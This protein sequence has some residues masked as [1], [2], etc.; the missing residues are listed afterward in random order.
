MKSF[1]L[2]LLSVL[3][4]FSSIAQTPEQLVNWLPSIDGWEKSEK[5]ETF[6]PGTLYERI[7]GAADAFVAC[8]FQEMTTLDYTNTNDEKLYINISMYRHA[9]IAD[10]YCIYASERSPDVEFLTVGGEGYL[11]G[12][13]LHFMVGALYVKVRSH[14][15]DPSVINTMKNIATQLSQKID[16]NPQ[17]PI[18]LGCLPK[19]DIIKRSDLYIAEN[20]MGHSFLH[21]AYQASYQAGE[22][23]YTAFIIEA[24]DIEEALKMLGNYLKLAKNNKKPAEGKFTIKDPYN[25]EIAIKVKGRYIMGITLDSK[26]SINPDNLIKQMES[27]L[28]S[29]H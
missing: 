26:P 17:L 4:P 10:A 22:K 23:E 5:V 13:S 12:S 8:K 11:T 15:E 3:I 7:N 19:E 25:G 2:L 21:S 28:E 29:I 27:A 1:K 24:A 20:F 16:P 6:N 18:M 9:S 14:S